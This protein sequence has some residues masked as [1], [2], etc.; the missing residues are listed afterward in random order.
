MKNVKIKSFADRVRDVVR[1]IQK[2]I[3]LPYIEVAR[4][5][6]NPNAAH[7]VGSIMKNNYDPSVPCH[8]VIRTDGSLGGYNRGGATVKKRLLQ[9]E[10]AR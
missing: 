3:T 4:R 8:R 9:K 1:K 2:G 10:K 5:A 6:G 7:A